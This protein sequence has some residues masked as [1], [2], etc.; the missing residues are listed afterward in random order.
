MSILHHNANI[1]HQIF[2]RAKIKNQNDLNQW[3]SKGVGVSQCL[4]ESKSADGKNFFLNLNMRNHPRRKYVPY[5]GL[6][7][8]VVAAVTDLKKMFKC[9]KSPHFMRARFEQIFI[10]V[11]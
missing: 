11:V 5:P 1:F 3:V 10:T 6:R 8:K 7:L 4:V 2:S 9:L